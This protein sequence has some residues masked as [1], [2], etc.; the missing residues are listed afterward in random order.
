LS[1]DRFH[2]A[3]LGGKAVEMLLD[4]QNNA[5]AVLQYNQEQGFYVDACQGH[6]L[7][8]QWGQIH[9]R[10]VH[11]TLYD[12]RLM[13]PSSVG[14]EYLLPIFTAAIGHDDMEHV[15]ETLFDAGNLYR[16]YHSVNTDIQKRIRHLEGG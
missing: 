2:A 6:R 11:P 9:A 12:A 3:Q 4:G 16:R 13:Q 14:I 15:R 10:T 7:R 8:D 5:L 1:F